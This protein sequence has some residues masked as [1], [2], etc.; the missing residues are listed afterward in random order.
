MR[1]SKLC[2][3]IGIPVL[4]MFALTGQCAN[5]MHW[6]VAGDQRQALVVVPAHP[7]NTKLPLLFVFH[8]HGGNMRFAERGQAFHESW[9]EAIV[10]YPQGLPTQ[11]YLGDLRGR[12]PGWQHGAGENGDRDLKF[13]DAMIETLC[14][15]YSVDPDRIYAT[16]FSNGGFFCYLLWAARPQ[17]FAAV[18][19]GAAS[20][21]PSI[22]LR[23]PKPA[24]IYGGRNDRRVQFSAQEA[25]MDAARNV[26]GCEKNG[27]TCGD[28]CLLFTSTRQAPV[29]TFIHDG[30]HVFVPEVKPLIVAFFKAHSR[31]T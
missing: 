10:V 7:A 1:T 16:G 11:G 4:L 31:I 26:N 28:K 20:L 24:F 5:L 17:T 13:V 9:P 27:I 2:L 21:V 30:D 23:A 29:M 19:P 18:A 8:G 25:A 6:N 12:L 15:K 3:L 22:Q 14:S